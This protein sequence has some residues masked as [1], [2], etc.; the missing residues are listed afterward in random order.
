VSWLPFLAVVVVAYVVPGPDLAVI[1][2]AAAVGRRC[3][4][5]AALGAQTGLCA[6]M[7]LA[8]GGLSLVLAR[9]PGVLAAIRLAGAAYLVYLGVRAILAAGRAA[10]D[11]GREGPTRS[12][13][14]QG[15]VTNLLNPK[16]VLFF[17]SILPQFVDPAAAPAPQV[18]ALGVADVLAGVAVW[19]VWI[20]L[21]G[22]LAAALAD[23]RRRR[24][25]DRATG[26]AFVAVGVALVAAA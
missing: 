10:P 14:A 3:A 19:A 17:A 25:W 26:G 8:A 12:W 5:R 16:A 9:S 15:L 21:T 24:V 4:L 13:F 1:L 7:L 22:G 20:A 18:L 23:R 2:R 6:H 11:D